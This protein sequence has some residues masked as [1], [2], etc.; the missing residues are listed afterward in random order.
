[1]KKTLEKQKKLS[2]FH[3]FEAIMDDVLYFL[4]IKLKLYAY[5]CLII[6]KLEQKKNGEVNVRLKKNIAI[7]GGY[8]YSASETKLNNGQY[9]QL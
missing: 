7:V 4:N 9:L 3:K 6:W 2:L 5:F 8:P 1:M